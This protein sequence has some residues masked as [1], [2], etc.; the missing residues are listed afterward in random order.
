MTVLTI[1]VRPDLDV[2]DR[3]RLKDQAADAYRRATNTTEEIGVDV[4]PSR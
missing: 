1:I 3:L 4:F 2:E